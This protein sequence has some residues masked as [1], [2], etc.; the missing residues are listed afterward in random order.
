MTNR[1][2]PELFYLISQQ[3]K[4]PSCFIW[5]LLSTSPLSVHSNRV[6]SSSFHL[7]FYLLPSSSF[8]QKHTRKGPK[9]K[10]WGGESVIIKK[11]PTNKKNSVPL[12]QDSTVSLSSHNPLS[13]WCLSEPS[14]VIG[15]YIV[16]LSHPHPTDMVLRDL[17]NGCIRGERKKPVKNSSYRPSS[18][19]WSSFSFYH[20]SFTWCVSILSSRVLLQNVI[21]ILWIEKGRPKDYIWV[22]VRWKTKN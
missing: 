16:R 18:H 1:E 15:Q 13:P 6:T 10:H 3:H 20:W 9:K 19:H 17:R 11:R 21:Y 7:L 4:H 2:T 12:D 14:E 5:S 8:P 22:P